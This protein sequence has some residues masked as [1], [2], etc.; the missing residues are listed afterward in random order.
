MKSIYLILSSL[1]SACL[2]S[3]ETFSIGFSEDHMEITRSA[4][5][6]IFEIP[7]KLENNK[8][9]NWKDYYLEV[10]VI[11][12]DS[13]LSRTSYH[14]DFSRRYIT[15]LG[16]ENQ[17]YLKIKKDE[18]P[19]RVRTI[20]LQLNAYDKE[21]K[22]VKD[23]NSSKNQILK[24]IVQPN[25]DFENRK[26]ES[27]VIGSKNLEIT[28]VFGAK[29]I[30][31]ESAEDMI[32]RK[33]SDNTDNLPA[34]K[35]DIKAIIKTVID[36]NKNN[37]E[38][39]G[40]ITVKKDVLVF[41]EKTIEGLNKKSIDKKLI[42]IQD[43]I[44]YSKEKF[45]AYQL[46]PKEGN[47]STAHFIEID[48]V[49]IDINEGMIEYIKVFLND[50]SYF[51]N[52]KAP[53]S[54][55]DIENRSFDKLY[56]FSGDK[57][58]YLSNAISFD[59][60]KRFNFLPDDGKFLLEKGKSKTLYKN[61][62]VNSLI[63]LT[64]YSDMLGLL[65]DEANSLI[66]FEANSKFY[67]HR[68]NVRNSFVYLG[69]S[70]QPHFHYNKLDSKFETL[71]YEKSDSISAIEIYRRLN[72]SVDMD[73]SLVRWDWRPSNSIELKIGYA[74]TSTKGTVGD[75]QTNFITI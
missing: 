74:Y 23:K 48:S 10:S 27:Q 57:F 16:S 26:T 41:E 35:E 22:I 6:K 51:Y 70:I 63:N 61:S 40:T 75:I 3:Q 33:E 17:I 20:V 49:K 72:Y 12:A 58:I 13:D 73:L 55:L 59:Y 14:I 18:N 31:N 5:D 15:D 36:S 45:Q 1:F 64:A 65:G 7:F 67:L 68:M 4:E 69:S 42:V 30:E 60:D 71:D 9:I 2:F 32:I 56:N 43:S 8:L 53:I 25:K 47:G 34:T 28:K 24:I 46:K 39:I 37:N 19:D 50:A 54:V 29:K 21:G 66:S 38:K 52:Q 62:N 44:N 11:Y